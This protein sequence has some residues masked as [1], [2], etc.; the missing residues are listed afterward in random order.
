MFAGLF[1]R[2]PAA[3]VPPS[4]PVSG[5]AEISALIAARP[6]VMRI[7]EFVLR[8]VARMREEQDVAGWY[9]LPDQIDAM[10]AEL[11]ADLGVAPH[12]P[13]QVREALL[14]LPGIWSKR[15]R[16]CG[17]PSMVGVR[18]A[19]KARGRDP[20][21]ATIY[22]VPSAHAA[23]AQGEADDAPV[24]PRPDAMAGHDA[25]RAAGGQRAA[26]AKTPSKRRTIADVRE[27]C[28]AAQMRRAA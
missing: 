11:A 28:E 19:L 8:L 16:T 25:A 20:D 3:K 1:S 15:M 14:G 10:A 26:T 7:D 23:S 18:A 9:Y 22:Y 21:R 5:R 6:R 13:E 4:P 24:A 2:K 17:D 12:R 27:A